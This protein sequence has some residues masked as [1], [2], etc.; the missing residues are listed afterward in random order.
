MPRPR[1]TPPPPKEPPSPSPDAFPSSTPPPLSAGSGRPTSPLTMPPRPPPRRPSRLPRRQPVPP[2]LDAVRRR[3]LTLAPDCPVPAYPSPADPKPRR[4]RFSP[5]L[6]RPTAS[7]SPFPPVA[8]HCTVP[9]R[10]PY[11]ARRA[12]ASSYLWSP[13]RT[14]PVAVLTACADRAVAR[15]PPAP[16]SPYPAN[17]PRPC[18]APLRRAMHSGVRRPVPAPAPPGACPQN[19]EK[20]KRNEKCICKNK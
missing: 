12:Q 16:R 11:R 17:R 5:S 19:F 13:S 9:A 8:A 18:P 14:C 20:V 6:V 1:P 4:P 15:R 10:A 7:A 3:L 2:S